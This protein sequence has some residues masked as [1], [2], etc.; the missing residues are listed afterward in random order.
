MSD[1]YQL[2]EEAGPASSLVNPDSAPPEAQI[3]ERSHTL[4]KSKAENKLLQK[5]YGINE[6]VETSTENDK[7]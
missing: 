2:I 1:N 5:L 4:D 7:G 6:S 3:E